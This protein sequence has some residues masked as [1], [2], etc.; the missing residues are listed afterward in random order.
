[1]ESNKKSLECHC[2][3]LAP[4]RAQSTGIIACSIKNRELGSWGKV[5]SSQ[6]QELKEQTSCFY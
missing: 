3:G 4:W 6:A 5:A 2:Q 1:M